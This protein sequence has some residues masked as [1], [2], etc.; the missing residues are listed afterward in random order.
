VFESVIIVSTMNK[1][2]H[3]THLHRH[4]QTHTHTHTHH[5][6]RKS[7]NAAAIMWRHRNRTKHWI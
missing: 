6:M 5:I 7:R 1:E 2:P 3:D 4:K